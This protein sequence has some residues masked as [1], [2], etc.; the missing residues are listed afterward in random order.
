[1]DIFQAIYERRSI[2]IFDK[3]KPIPEEIL[4]KI[5]NASRNISPIPTGDYPFRFIVVDDS[6]TRELLATSA[7]EIAAMMFGSSFEV[8]GPGHLWYLSEKARLKVAEYTTTGELWTYPREAD[9]VLVPLYTKASWMDTPSV[10]SDHIDIYLQYLGMATQNM[11][12]VAH[13]Y[14]I[15]SAYNGMPLVDTRRRELAETHLGLPFS[16]E[17]TGAVCFGYPREKR[18]YGPARA[19]LDQVVFKDYWGVPYERVASRDDTYEGIRFEERD[20]EDVIEN[21]NFV[22]S[23]DDG[24][25]PE[26]K[27][28]KVMDCALWGP[29]PENFRNWRFILIRDK[30]SKEF[31]KKLIEEK[32]HTP[33]MFNWGE[34]LLSKLDYMDD[35]AR[36]RE[37]EK[38]FSQGLGGWVS[39]CDTLILVLTTITNWR[40]QPD[41]SLAAN[42]NHMWALSTGCCIQ[43]MILAATALDLGVNYDVWS[44]SDTRE[45]ELLLEYFGVPALTWLPLGVLGLGRPGE[46]S[47]SQTALPRRSLDSLFY[48]ELWGAESD[49]EKKYQ[50]SVGGK[51]WKKKD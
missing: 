28:E 42:S 20:V 18:Y 40:D 39:E 26:W 41:A 24:E 25:V 38:L 22:D 31:I 8:F 6:E 47:Y 51:P 35:N 13:K 12:L 17:A 16:W 36:L 44:C 27:I 3:E 50:Q 34:S 7:K 45:V 48:R 10:L 30:E 1:M 9:L 19:Q 4:L 49:Y 5:L 43:N 32:I 11:W 23:F 33:W 37:V 46:K 14:G 29:S 15:G 21:I 2:R